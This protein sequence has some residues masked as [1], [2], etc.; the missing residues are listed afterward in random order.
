LTTIVQALRYISELFHSYDVDRSGALDKIEVGFMFGLFEE[1]TFKDAMGEA[2][3]PVSNI[4]KAILSCMDQNT[5][6]QADGE[7][8]YDEFIAAVDGMDERTT[9]KDSWELANRIKHI[10]LISESNNNHCADAVEA[11]AVASRQRI[12]N[13][14]V[15]LRAKLEVAE[16]E[17]VAL[18]EKAER[19]G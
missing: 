2:G 19:S 18:C 5:E 9:K 12:K 7:I 13:L 11:V 14:E 16:R 17:L 10:E 15:E 1:K 6:A 8:M 4:K 3:I